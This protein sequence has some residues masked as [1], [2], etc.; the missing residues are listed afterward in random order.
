MGLRVD[1]LADLPEQVRQ[2]V[3][4]KIAAQASNKYHNRKIE[5][6]GIRFDSRK[7]AKRYVQLM[8]AMRVGAIRDL[9]LQVDFTIQEAY[10]DWHG[11]RIRA[12]RYR[13]DF[14]YNLTGLLPFGISA[15]DR[16][17]WSRYI[18]SGTE[19]VIEDVKGVKTQAYKMKEKLMAKKGVSIREV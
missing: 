12:I 18:M 4:G 2:Q 9:R 1:S 5:I 8:H 19:T 6:N 16:D 3:G 11:K 10:T 14:A 13:A 15:E 7:E 17:V